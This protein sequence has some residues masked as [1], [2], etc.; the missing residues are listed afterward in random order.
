MDDPQF[1]KLLRRF[2][3]RWDGY[4]KVRKGVKKRITGHM[5]QLDCRNMDRYL[6]RLEQDKEL[7][8]QCERLMTVPIS[9]FFR[10]PRLWELL[11]GEL[12]PE[13]AC[14]ERHLFKVWCAGCACGE[15]A[16]SFKILWQ[17]LR[18][19]HEHVPELELCAT[20]LNPRHLERAYRGTYS[21]SSL[22]DLPEDVHQT[23]FSLNPDGSCTALAS[24]RE[25]IQWRVQHL[26]EEDPPGTGFHLI[27]LRNSILTYLD[28]ERQ[29][30]CLQRVV[31]ALRPGGYLVIGK[32]ER[33][34]KAFLPLEPLSWSSMVFRRNTEERME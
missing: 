9:R 29:I 34:P 25:G 7:Q 24:L 8:V 16:L 4:R 28:R 11:M 32:R 22:R 1:R 2:G 26:E 17:R 14:R 33:L 30:P 6:D 21:R 19:R 18:N 10:D 31:G 12:L 27:F 13:V 5:E 20:D 15:E 3:F 23:C